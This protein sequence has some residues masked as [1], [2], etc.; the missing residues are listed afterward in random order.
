VASEILPIETVREALATA[1]AIRV[2]TPPHGRGT[3]ER[4]WDLFALHKGD[5]PVAFRIEERDR[6]LVVRIDVNPQIRVRPSE[7][8]VAAVEKICGRGSVSLR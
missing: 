1:V 2:S 4:L 8:L 5:R 3:F 6:R 7:Q